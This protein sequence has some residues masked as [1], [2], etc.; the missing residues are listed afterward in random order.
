[1]LIFRRAKVEDFEKIKQIIKDCGLCDCDLERWLN[2][3]MVAEEDGNVIGTGGIENYGEYG[4]LCSVAVLP[5]FRNH[6]IGDGLVRSLINL[7]DRMGIKTL[8]LFTDKA[9][10]FFER[11][12]F[13]KT[14][15]SEI[16][17]NCPESKQ[18]SSCPLSF[19]PMRLNINEFF[20]NI[21]CK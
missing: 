10:N 17:E 15:R 1:M 13:R 16:Q 4:I 3:F 9:V 8:F 20:E 5:D 11:V 18:L 2:N 12:G 14:N 21:K 7:A 6:G 19:I